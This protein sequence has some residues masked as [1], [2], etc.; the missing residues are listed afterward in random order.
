MTTK[1]VKIKFFLFSL[2]FIFFINNCYSQTINFE[3]AN[4]NIYVSDADGTFNLIWDHYLTYENSIIT[5]EHFVE[6]P[7]NMLGKADYWVVYRDDRANFPDLSNY[8]SSVAIN[9]LPSG[10][11]KFVFTDCHDEWYYSTLETQCRTATI[12]LSVPPKLNDSG[13][14]PRVV[15]GTNGTASVYLG[16]DQQFDRPVVILQGYTLFGKTPYFDTWYNNLNQSG[17]LSTLRS[18]GYDIVLYQYYDSTAGIAAAAS[19]LEIMLRRFN[20]IDFPRVRSVSLYG[21]SMGGVVARYA[22]LHLKKLGVSNKVTTWISHD[23]PHLGAYVPQ[24]LIDNIYKLYDK[25]DE[26]GC[27]LSS[28]CRA[29][30]REVKRYIT[31]INKLTPSE[32]L[33]NAPA[34]V[35][36]RNSLISTL[37]SMGNFPSIPSLGIANG[38]LSSPQG[39]ATSYKVGEFKLDR[40][41]PYQNIFFALWNNPTFENRPGGYEDF[42]SIFMETV[43]TASSGNISNIT[44]TSQKHTFVTTESALSGSPTASPFTS[45]VTA[46]ITT[47]N[48]KHVQQTSIKKNAIV[49]WLNAYQR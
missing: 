15:G 29:G 1:F 42:Y 12:K 14:F 45:I 36:A 13:M 17:L 10:Q 18:Q 22:L 37:N 23:A 21:E 46:D 44:Y 31:D 30:R 49:N 34:G 47:A 24:T 16:A 35:N 5:V 7:L 43:R 6:A 2:T 28:S 38:T 4:P 3:T 40:P 8:A 9:N 11:H 19:G 27:G 20:T 32:L 25:I 48:E 41:W 26:N 33:I 39:A